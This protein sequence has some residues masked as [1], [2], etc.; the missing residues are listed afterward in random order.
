MAAA[1]FVFFVPG[2]GW[3]WAVRD[4]AT[5]LYES[6]EGYESDTIAAAVGAST[7][8]AD[9]PGSETDSTWH[10][11]GAAGEP[12]FE[13]SWSGDFAFRISQT[14][15]VDVQAILVADAELEIVTLPAAY[16]PTNR[17]FM[18]AQNMTTGLP[19]LVQI[20]EVDATGDLPGVVTLTAAASDAVIIAG[21]F[22]QNPPDFF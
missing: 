15:Q 2:T 19:G 17:A 16:R 11:V 8:G 13:N 4:G 1:S 3:K 18:V 14:G 21:S 22:F 7:L 12:A 5:T 9:W 20:F 6:D 10:Y